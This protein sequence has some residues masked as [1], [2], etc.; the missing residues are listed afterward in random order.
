[1]LRT[2]K[3]KVRA[4]VAATSWLN[5]SIASGQD[6]SRRPL[7]RTLSIEFFKTGIQFIGC[8]GTL[9][10]RTWAPFSDVG[11]FE[12]VQPDFLTQPVDRVIV[13]DIDKFGIGFMR[14]LASALGEDRPAEL[15]V[16][17]EPVFDLEKPALGDEVQR[18]VLTLNALGQTLSL[19]LFEGEYP[20]WRELKLGLDRAELVD[21]MTLGT[22]MFR[23]V[24]KLIGITGVDCSFNGEDR[25]IEVRS[26]GSIGPVLHGLLM[27][28]RRPSKPEA[29]PAK[30]EQTEALSREDED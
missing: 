1:M 7:Y 8:D 20:N 19:K 28:M 15:S 21:G 27:P 14:T 13:A 18:Y 23:A 22:K 6:D 10:F 4:D 25:A 30:V 12:L 29:K 5:A 2:H 3:Y 24:G 11:D 17:V 16:D 9:L 26:H